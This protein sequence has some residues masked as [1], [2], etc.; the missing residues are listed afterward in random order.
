MLAKFSFERRGPGDEL[1]AETVVDHCETTGGKRDTLTVDAGD[2]FPF[3]DGMTRE[4][5][6]GSDARAGCIEFTVPQRIEKV[7][8][9]EDALALSPRETFG[10]E[11]LGARLQ[12]VP[13][14]LAE[15]ALG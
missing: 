3:G 1:E 12:R 8:R 6:L 4:A 10:D 7:S 5:G 11:M 13:H 15:A 14:V 2:G 9:E